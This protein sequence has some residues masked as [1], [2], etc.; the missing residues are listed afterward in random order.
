MADQR[1]IPQESLTE[2]EREIVTLIAQ[3]LSNQ[4]IA[5]QLFL[6]LDTVKWYNR[7]IFQK[8][9][10]HSRTQAIL[11]VRQAGVLGERAP[12]LQHTLPEQGTRFIGRQQELAAIQAR[13]ADPACRLLTLLGPGGIGKSRLAI[14]AA[15]HSLASYP[16]GVYLVPFAPVIAAA[17]V[18]QA[19]ADGV[20][21]VLTN[22]RRPLDQLITYLREKRLLLLLDNFEH[23]VAASDLLGEL[24]AH[25]KGAK[26]LVTSRE[27]LHLHEEWVFDVQGLHYPASGR[28]GQP[29]ADPAAYEAGQLFLATAQRTQ[30]DFVPAAQDQAQIARICQLVGGMPLGIELAASWLR[31]LPCAEIARGIAQDLALL[32]SAWRDV[33][34]RH[35]SIQA[36]LDH[37]WQLLSADEQEV[38]RRLTV[39]SGPF[40]REAAAAV[41]DSSL[42]LLLTRLLA[43]VDKSFVRRT[44]DERFSIHELVKQYGSEKLQADPETWTATRRRHCCYHAALLAERTA[45]PDA[46]PAQAE[47]ES[48]FDDL[49]AAWRYA[50]AS[51][52]VAQIQQLAEGFLRYYR[53]HSWYR[54]GSGALAVYQQALACFDPYAD[55]AEQR[56]ALAC[57]YESIGELQELA[58]AHQEAFAAFEQAVA[59]TAE[60]DYLRRGRLY[61]RLAD[62]WVAMYQHERGHEAYTLAESLLAQ[63]PHRSTAW[64]GEWLHIALQRMLL[65]YWQNRL[66]EIDALARQIQP[67]IEQHGSVTQRVLYLQMLGM[68]ALRRARYFYSNEAITYTGEALALSLASGNLGDIALTHF[69]HGFS[70]LWS[71]HLDEAESYIQLA[72]ELAA[73]NGDLTLLARTVTYLAVVYRKRGDRERVRLVTAEGLRIAGE[74]KMPQYTGMARGHYAWLAWRAG[75]LDETKRQAGAAIADWGGLG[76]A[77]SLVGCRWLTLFPL[78]GVCLQE[79]DVAAAVH[80]AQHL[81]MPSQHRL[82]DALTTLLERAVAAGKNGQMDAAGD[83]LRQALQLAREL[84]Y[85]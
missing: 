66:E 51:R 45:A 15:R 12:A 48:V 70:H 50:V 82:P 24:L 37:S 39:F 44:E 8:L 54:A 72:R 34:A 46:G 1:Q 81:I 20:G 73:Q 22:Q 21:F 56:A 78:L 30:A 9:G 25:W 77:Q 23:L 5:D 29:G 2:R 42:I 67:L 16:D 71:D 6:T 14:E 31:L 38:F 57:L 17:F 65:Y 19:L 80:W 83:L 13:L 68:M 36:V 27:R 62:V 26:L 41:A 47:V 52:Q 11:S 49:Q 55:H 59:H 4:Q 28:A 7:Q 74:A 85:I 33:P 61:G 75:D 60:H 64:W 84:H 58:T 43:L 76:Q 18:V 40:G 63:A 53:L 35:R 69:N 79:A 32:T 3:G 10:V